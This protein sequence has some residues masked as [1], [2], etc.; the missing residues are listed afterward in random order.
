MRVSAKANAPQRLSDLP[1]IS[2]VLS[3][4]LADAGIET[5]DELFALGSREAFLRIRFR[6]NTACFC[7]LCALEGAIR[8][9]RWHN[10]DDSVKKELRNFFDTL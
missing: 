9:I 8:G 4:V 6:D 5:P 7:K 1:N 10:L 3:S 2:K